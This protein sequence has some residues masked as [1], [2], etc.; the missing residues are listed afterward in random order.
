MSG[1][2]FEDHATKTIDWKQNINNI[3]NTTCHFNIKNHIYIYNLYRVQIHY[4]HLFTQK[5]I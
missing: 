1:W 5:L 4:K 3:L 2:E